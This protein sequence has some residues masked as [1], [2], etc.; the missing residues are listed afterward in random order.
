MTYP[1]HDKLSVWQRIATGKAKLWLGDAAAIVSEIINHPTG[2]RSQNT[3]IAG[4]EIDEIKEMMRTVETWGYAHGCHREI[5]NG[6]KGWLRAFEGYTEF[7][8]RKQ[9]DLL[10]PGETARLYR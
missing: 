4:G 2:V 10:A 8:W 7:G 3:W 1:T 9:K 6:R 5:G